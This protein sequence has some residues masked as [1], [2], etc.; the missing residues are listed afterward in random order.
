MVC[1]PFQINLWVLF[2]HCYAQSSFYTKKN[3]KRNGILKI[4]DTRQNTKMEL[5]CKSC[6][7]N[8]LSEGGKIDSLY[9]NPLYHW[10]SNFKT[11]TMSK[12]LNSRRFEVNGVAI[13]A[14][15]R[16]RVVCSTYLQVS[17]FSFL[18]E[19]SQTKACCSSKEPYC[20]ILQCYLWS[21]KFV[22]LIIFY[23]WNNATSDRIEKKLLEKWPN[24]FLIK[25][26]F[27]SNIFLEMLH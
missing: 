4:L 23:P 10:N 5:P 1:F 19:H 7:F 18:G 21:I 8:Y 9:F 3:Q 20:V 24:F 14:V 22:E 13:C 27:S 26:Y 11:K 17:L 6:H 16:A 25:G 12:Q 2:S 15:P